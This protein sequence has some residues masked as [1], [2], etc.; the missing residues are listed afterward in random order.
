MF[1]IYIYNIIYI[2]YVNRNEYKYLINQLIQKNVLGGNNT[3]EDSDKIGGILEMFMDSYIETFDPSIIYTGRDIALVSGL[4]YR[5]LIVYDYDQEGIISLL[6]DLA[7][8]TGK[9][10]VINDQNWK[11]IKSSWTFTLKND[12]K[13]LTDC[14]SNV[15]NFTPNSSVAGGN[16]NHLYLKKN[17]SSYK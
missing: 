12:V 8:D 13:E 7:T 1:K 17:K 5:T 10:V 4:I 16:L 15:G 3:L 11:P 2:M 9:Y 14:G 6:P